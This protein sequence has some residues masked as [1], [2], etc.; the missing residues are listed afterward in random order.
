MTVVCGHAR[1]QSPDAAPQDMTDLATGRVVRDA[2]HVSVGE[3]H[4]RAL[5]PDTAQG[6][7]S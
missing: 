3:G 2:A 4:V 6:D 5:T 1:G 7:G